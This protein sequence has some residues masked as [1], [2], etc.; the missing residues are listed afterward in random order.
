MA[1]KQLNKKVALI[2]SAAFVLLVLAAIAVFLRLTQ[3]PDEFIKDGDAALLV[4][5]YNEAVRGYNKAIGL[6]KTDSLRKV[7]HFKLADVYIETDEWPKVLGHWSAIVQIDPKN[8]KA[9]FGRLKYY[10]II[11]DRQAQYHFGRK[12]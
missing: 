9:R 2:G 6:A 8:T 11:A 4:E 7:L 10:Y 3:K 5:D 12:P 1:R